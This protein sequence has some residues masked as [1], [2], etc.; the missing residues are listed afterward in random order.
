[1][2]AGRHFLEQADK[3]PAVK[4]EA[5]SNGKQLQII[6]TTAEVQFPLLQPGDLG[7]NPVTV[8]QFVRGE[9]GTLG[10]EHFT[11][12]AVV[13]LPRLS[14][15]T[16]VSITKQLPLGSRFEEWG[17]VREYWRDVH[18]VEFRKEGEEPRV[19]YNVSFN[20]GPAMTYPEW[21]VGCGFK[22]KSV[23]YFMARACFYVERHTDIKCLY[24]QDLVTFT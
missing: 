21:S 12:P 11:Q 5:R 17:K 23:N 2:L 22:L 9:E 14:S 6:L 8:Q 3:I 18:G 15:A 4:L 20:G 1:M 19:Y 13:V 16:L 7:I 24:F 10:R